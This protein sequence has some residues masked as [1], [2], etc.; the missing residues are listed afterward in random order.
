MKSACRLAA[1]A[2]IAA[3]TAALIA[4]C[5]LDAQA[6]SSTQMPSLTITDDHELTWKFDGE[7]LAVETFINEERLLV[8]TYQDH[9]RS[10]WHS[11]GYYRWLTDGDDEGDD[12]EE[13]GDPGETSPSGPTLLRG[14]IYFYRPLPFVYTNRV[15]AGTQGL[16]PPGGDGNGSNNQHE[17]S[18]ILAWSSRPEA[19][20]ERVW[21]FNTAPDG[22]PTVTV[23]ERE[24]T[25]SSTDGGNQ[26]AVRELR[27]GQCVLVVDKAG[28]AL[29]IMEE[30]WF[31]GDDKDIPSDADRFLS[32]AL[33]KING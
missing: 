1:A 5:T 23:R 32:H 18:G 13:P 22:G 27:P 24:D 26:N 10:E 25:V 3:A 6:T 12:P 31:R 14:W 8:G 17:P 20:Y 16:L 30:R 28:E 33:P 7:D 15:A 21:I 11:E 4:A 2:C 19:G 29:E 9:P